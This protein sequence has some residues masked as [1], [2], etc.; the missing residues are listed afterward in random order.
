MQLEIQKSVNLGP[1][2]RKQTAGIL[3][4]ERDYEI[5]RFL[6]EM[7][8]ARIDELH[9]QFF[10]RNQDNS[11]SE[12]TIYAWERLSALRRFGFINSVRHYDDARSY[13][14]PTFKAYHAVLNRFPDRP[15]CKPQLTIDMR[16][17]F[18]D[19]QV[20][21]SRMEL[22]A[23]QNVSDWLSDRLLKC[24]ME[25]QFGLS[26]SQVPD[27]IFRLPN[28]ERVA[29]ELEVAQK[30]KAKY[31]EKIARYVRLIR[32]SRADTEMFK[33]VYYRVYKKCVFEFLKAETRMFGGMFEIEFI[34]TPISFRRE[35]P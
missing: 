35:A 5:L 17:F 33:Q 34:E 11:I 4:K 18:H 21:M 8:F 22:E 10:R 12:S 31:R 7:K 27:A 25:N 23:K 29:F 28:R 6:I 24:A 3:L 15:I 26:A 32:D 13:Y 9:F 19:L 16:T 1:R 2:E 30:A 14:L 20:L